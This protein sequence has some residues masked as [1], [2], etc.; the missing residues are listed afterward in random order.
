MFNKNN[1]PDLFSFE[2]ELSKKQ[3]DLLDV[4]KRKWFYKLIFFLTNC[5]MLHFFLTHLIFQIQ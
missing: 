4:S 3:R 5:Q 2:T 1:Q